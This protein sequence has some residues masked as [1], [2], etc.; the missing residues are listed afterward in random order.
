MLHRAELKDLPAF[1]HHDD[2]PRMLS[3]GSLDPCAAFGDADDFRFIG[4]PVLLLKILPHIAKGC[5]IGD[6]ADGSRLEG[7]AFTKDNLCVFMGFSLVFP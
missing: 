6:G 5:L 1:G 4:G 2:A 7:G 3:R